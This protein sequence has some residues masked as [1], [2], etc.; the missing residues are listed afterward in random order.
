MVELKAKVSDKGQVLIPKIFRERYGI[1]E[2]GSVK[3]EPTG[4]G[5]LIKGRPPLKEVMAM[6]EAHTER[7]REL[8]VKG[9]KLGDLKKVYLE[10]EFKEGRN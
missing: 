7:I 9:P 5:L 6:L 4:E 8:G 3:F 1:E 10:M 2:G